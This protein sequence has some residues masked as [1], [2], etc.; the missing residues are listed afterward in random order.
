M[1]RNGFLPTNWTSSGLVLPFFAQGYINTANNRVLI[2][3]SN[4]NGSNVTLD[5]ADIDLLNPSDGSELPFTTIGPKKLIYMRG[6]ELYSS[7]GSTPF[8]KTNINFSA[9]SRPPFEISN[10]DS[11]VVAASAT[12]VILPSN[13]IGLLRMAIDPMFT[14]IEELPDNMFAVVPN[15]VRVGGDINVVL[16]D[17]TPGAEFS[18]A[19]TDIN[20][21]FIWQGN[22]NG[23]SR[24]VIPAPSSAGVYVVTVSTENQH[25]NRKVIVGGE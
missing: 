25:Y 13:S 18:V 23:Q 9:S 6:N 7:A 19:L 17:N 1:I 11:V 3:Y 24:L 16:S 8:L 21:R 15:P 4:E 12:Q 10:Y 5:L 20:G 2:A 22:S 14:S